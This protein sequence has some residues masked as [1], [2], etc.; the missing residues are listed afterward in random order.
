M[1]SRQTCLAPIWLFHIL[2]DTA[3]T[4][5][6]QFIL[7]RCPV[8]TLKLKMEL[9]VALVKCYLQLFQERFLGHLPNPPKNEEK[10]MS[11]WISLTQHKNSQWIHNEFLCLDKNSL[12]N[13]PEGRGLRW[14]KGQVW[15]AL[16]KCTDIHIC[17]CCNI[18]QGHRKH[19]TSSG[20]TCV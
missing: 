7:Y 9:D 17:K 3:V 11:E 18:D 13:I 12:R 14:W 1:C 16:W 4:I 19:I 20:G 10:Q 15:T 6:L 8:T 5:L 2:S